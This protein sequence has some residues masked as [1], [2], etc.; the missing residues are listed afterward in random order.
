MSEDAQEDLNWR[1]QQLQ[2]GDTVSVS[3]YSNRRYIDVTGQ[4][5][6]IN[7]DERYIRVD[8]VEIPLDDI[9]SVE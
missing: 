5:R 9:L 1:L 3:Y 2:I 8:G 4:V 7:T 6:R